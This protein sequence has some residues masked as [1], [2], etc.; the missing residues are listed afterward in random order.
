MTSAGEAERERDRVSV[1]DRTPFYKRP[2]CSSELPER[3][4]TARDD[5][6]FQV[7]HSFAPQVGSGRAKLSPEQRRRRLENANRRSHRRALRSDLPRKAAGGRKKKKGGGRDDTS[8]FR[9]FSKRP[10]ISTFTRDQARYYRRNLKRDISDISGKR[11][12]HPRA[13]PSCR[14][15]PVARFSPDGTNSPGVIMLI[16]SSFP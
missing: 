1:N 3:A 10:T 13:T 8:V 14:R 7:G 16:L 9:D 12:A 5:I 4:I 2:F 11:R 15:S 6:I